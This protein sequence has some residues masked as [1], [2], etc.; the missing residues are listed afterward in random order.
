L[1]QEGS[2]RE[3]PRQKNG[4]G[5][6]LVYLSILKIMSWTPGRADGAFGKKIQYVCIEN[7]V[8]E[9]NETMKNK[10]LYKKRNTYYIALLGSAVSNTDVVIRRLKVL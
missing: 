9:Q 6:L 3:G 8:R 7:S 10:Q 2:R 4:L 1:G 5:H